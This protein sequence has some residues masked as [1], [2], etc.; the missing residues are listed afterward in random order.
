MPD[1]AARSTRRHFL[2]RVGAG[3]AASFL[4]PM[5]PPFLR[6]LMAQEDAGDERVFRAKFLWATSNGYAGKPVGE[7]AARLGMS[8]VGAPYIE[9]PLEA[10]GDEHLIV[11]LRAFDCVTFVESMLALARCVKAMASTYQDFS[12]ELRQIRYRGGNIKGYASRLHYFSEWVR[13]NERKGVVRDLTQSLGGISYRKTLNFMTTHR[14]SYAQLENDGV[15]QQILG[16]EHD[17][18]DAP[19]RFI[20]RAGVAKAERHMK[21]GDII[22]LTT[23]I[24]GL[25]VTHTGLAVADG[26]IIRFLH[27]PLSGGSVAY[28]EGT[29][30]EYV[31]HGSSSMSGIIIVRPQEP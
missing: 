30:G 8:F 28:P 22:G 29:L 11:N 10:Q 21:S 7:I 9:H 12:R 5:L 16:V 27:A 18:L 23:S 13:D 25:D 6:E 26:P 14:N 19:L 1:T 2:Y 24:D 3:A 20:P 17:L 31:N 15:Y 4:I